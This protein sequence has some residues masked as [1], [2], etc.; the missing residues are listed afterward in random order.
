MPLR[1][2]GSSR[3]WRIDGACRLVDVA[4]TAEDAT[5]LEAK[6]ERLGVAKRRLLALLVRLARRARVSDDDWRWLAD[7]EEFER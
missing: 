1:G 2:N 4:L 3:R 7:R 5:W 6:A